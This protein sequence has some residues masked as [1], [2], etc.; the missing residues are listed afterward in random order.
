MNYI[1]DRIKEDRL[2]YKKKM[3][4]PN[5]LKARRRAEK[6]KRIIYEI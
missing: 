6:I 2:L 3:Y 4:V 1:L 5:Y